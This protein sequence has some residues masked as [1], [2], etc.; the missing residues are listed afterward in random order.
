MLRSCF[1]S[2]FVEFRSEEKS[3]MSRPI[4][5]Q[6]DH[7]ICFS[8]RSQKYKL[9][10][11]RLDLASC[12]VSLNSVLRRGRECLGQS[13][14]MATTLF[15][16]LIGHKNTNLAED[17]E[18][19]L[20]AKF[21]KSKVYRPTCFSDRPQKTQALPR[22]LRSCFLSGFVELHSAV[23]EKSKMSRPIKGMGGN[24]VFFF[25]RPKNTNFMDEVDILLPV[26]F[27]WFPFRGE[28]EKVAA[29]RKLGRP[30]CFS[31]QPELEPKGALIV[32]LNIVSTSIIS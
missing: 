2:S 10:R 13:E 25:D 29:N 19:L 22:T 20:P 15:V 21:Q 3:R 14:A 7:L 16:F 32:H 24:L 31:D 1:L 6:G 18:I 30:C 4:R 11:G 5:G 27:R 9:G 8:D 28:V 23:A 12:Q 17:V 26:K